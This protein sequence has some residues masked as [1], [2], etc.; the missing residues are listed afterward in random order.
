MD[1]KPVVLVF[2][3]PNGSGKSTITKGIE[4]VGSYINPDEIK[5]LRN[6]S[7]EEAVKIAEKMKYQAIDEKNDFTFETVLSS[8]YNIDVLLYAKKHGYRVEIVYVIT[9]NPEINVERVKNR[10]KN[11]GHDVPE[12]KIRSRYYK[13]INNISKIL[14]IADIVRVIDNSESHAELIIK[15]KDGHIT[16]NETHLWNEDMLDELV[17]GTSMEEVQED[18]EINFNM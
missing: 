3:G 17:S 15:L 6:C 18:Q 16:M 14:K 13:S 5:K 2:A 12:Y 9:T 4:I 8:H 7:D 11:G 10:V 1:R